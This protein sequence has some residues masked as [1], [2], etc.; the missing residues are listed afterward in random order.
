M[1]QGIERTQVF[2]ADTD[3]DEFVNRLAELGRGGDVAAFVT[4]HLPIA[5]MGGGASDRAQDRGIYPEEERAGKRAGGTE[6]QDGLAGKGKMAE[7]D[8]AHRARV[9]AE[10]DPRVPN[11]VL[12]QQLRSGVRSQ[13]SRY[14]APRPIPAA[15]AW[16]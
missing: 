4:F 3:R 6:E 1:G 2:Q 12:P 10:A 13:E 14:A 15:L 7:S 8:E 16:A 5:R 9:R 11:Q